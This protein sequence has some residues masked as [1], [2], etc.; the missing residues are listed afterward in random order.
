MIPNEAEEL[1]TVYR[2]NHFVAVHKP[3]GLLVHRSR[4]SE[5]KEFLLQRLRNQIGQHVYP[6][7]RLDRATSGVII[8][9]LNSEAAQ[10]L[11]LAFTGQNVTKT[12]HAIVRGWLPEPELLVDHPLQDKETGT[13][14]QDAQTRFRELT[15]TELPFAVD[16]YPRARYSLVEAQPL[17]GRRH[18]I[19]KH[20][21]HIS[22]PIIGDIRYGKGTHNRFF[23][24]H[25]G[26]H[27]LL[28]MAQSLHF[29]HPFSK[30]PVAIAANEDQQWKDLLIQSGLHDRHQAGINAR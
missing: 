5:D 30:R 11:N 15:R 22:H 29:R 21:K 4:L 20:L 16:R 17:T 23:R 26:C 28:L 9:A 19:R 25:F 14:Y 10:L 24:D 3:A 7:H 12:Y 18:Q 2:D 27:R 13:P 8:F 6:V 1:A